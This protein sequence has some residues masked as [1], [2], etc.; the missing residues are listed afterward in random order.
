MT[1]AEPLDGSSFFEC[2]ACGVQF[3]DP[4][5]AGVPVFQDFTDYGRMLFGDL[6]GGGSIDEA[7]TPNERIV[8]GMLKKELSPGDAVFD[9]CCESGRFLAALKAHGFRPYGVDPLERP[10]GM[11]KEEGFPV[12]T[13]TMEAVPADWPQPKAVVI[14]ESMVRFPDPVRVFGEIRA[15]FPGATVYMTVPSP[16]QSLKL[17]DFDRRHA[18]PP[19][20]LVRWTVKGMVAALEK[21]GY[22][23]TGRTKNVAVNWPIRRGP[24]GN[25]LAVVLRLM[26]EAEYSLLAVGRPA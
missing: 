15:R 10:I 18:Y 11:L 6:R 2:G 25:T 9:F 7:L 17:P 13:G 21:A 24:F 23:A 12:E 3:V 19:H 20:H 8:L 22:R 4:L 26:G 16:R 14:L 1:L 5:P